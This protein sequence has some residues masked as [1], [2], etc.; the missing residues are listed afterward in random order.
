MPKKTWVV[1]PGATKT[2]SPAITSVCIRTT[3]SQYYNDHAADFRSVR[4]SCQTEQK[5][6]ASSYIVASLVV[7][8]EEP[9][10]VT[11]DLLVFQFLVGLSDSDGSDMSDL[12]D[13][14]G[15]SVDKTARLL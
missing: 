5:H 13:L 14:S 11:D 4:K 9:E 3:T 12:S 6:D 7:V 1:E 15:A 10:C 2:S 8:A